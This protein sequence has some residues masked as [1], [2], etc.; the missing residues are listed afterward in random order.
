MKT[1]PGS[2][3]ITLKSGAN[4]ECHYCSGLD[5]WPVN[6]HP[7]DNPKGMYSYTDLNIVSVDGMPSNKWLRIKRDDVGLIDI[8]RDWLGKDMR[9]Y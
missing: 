6:G 1:N 4:V 5:F 3:M 7:A 9:G 8:I 2:V